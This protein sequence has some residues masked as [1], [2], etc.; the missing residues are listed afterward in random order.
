VASLLLSST[1]GAAIDK[2]TTRLKPLL[3]SITLNRA[4]ILLACVGWYVLLDVL[5]PGT[6]SGASST[7]P[8]DDNAES[9]IT[10]HGSPTRPIRLY[11]FA[12]VVL[13]SIVEKLS[14]VANMLAMERDW[15]PAL[16]T[17]ATMSTSTTSEA[18]IYT[19]TR[20]NSVMRRI[21]LICKLVAPLVISFV[22]TTKGV[23]IGVIV[24]GGMSACSWAVEIV[25][26]RWVWKMNERL[27][28]PRPTSSTTSSPA[29]M[30]DRSSH[31]SW[32]WIRPM[33]L[34]KAQVQQIR[35]YF[36]T[37]VWVPSVALSLLHLSALSYAATFITYLLNSNFSLTLITVARAVGSV[38][39]VSST[40][41]APFGIRRLARTKR[42][43]QGVTGFDE[44]G[45]E[46]LGRGEEVNGRADQLHVVG[47]ARSGLWG[48]MLQLASLVSLRQS[49]I[50]RH[51]IASRVRD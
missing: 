25:T 10:G 44:D 34:L 37:D 24:V 16:A 41:V 39:E 35:A 11:L 40:F 51:S 1:V 9:S 31:G 5:K 33:Q 4:S 14:G 49:N 26:V 8:V 30:R 19:L 21:D 17:N 29:Q 43:E 22:V 46:L 3:L 38:V 32:L 23:S 7:I 42:W 15:V 50:L 48:L 45:E 2:S 18:S 20:L 12:T 27:R 13:I 28:E 47:L 6:E 36:S